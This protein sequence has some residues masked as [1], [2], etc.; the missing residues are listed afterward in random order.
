MVKCG[1]TETP[2]IDVEEL[3]QRYECERQKRHRKQGFSHYVELTG[4]LE[5]EFFEFDPYSPERTTGPVFDEIDV[6][7]LG[8]GFAGLI[9]AGRLKEVGVRRSAA[10][11]ETAHTS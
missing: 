4:N 5:E 9:A 1:S 2:E 6:V 11:A 8:G 10:K 7:V 3:R